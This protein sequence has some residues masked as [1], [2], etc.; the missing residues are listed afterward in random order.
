MVAAF[1]RFADG[2]VNSVNEGGHLFSGANARRYN[3]EFVAAKA[4][5][6]LALPEAFLKVKS[7]RLQQ[8]IADLMTERV[9]D[10]L[11]LVSVKKQNGYFALITALFELMAEV[12][13]SEGLK[14]VI[15]VPV[16]TLT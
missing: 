16:T 10:G 11:E 12:L 2:V 3:G 7:H 4:S 14:E 6:K 8:L 5:H 9:V 15:C 1:M 13:T